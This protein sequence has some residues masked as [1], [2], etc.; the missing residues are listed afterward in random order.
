[1]NDSQWHE[2]IEHLSLLKRDQETERQFLVGRRDRG[3]DLASAVRIFLEVLHGYEAQCEQDGV[4]PLPV[5]ADMHPFVG[6]K[7]DSPAPIAGI[8]MFDGLMRE[9]PTPQPVQTKTIK[10]R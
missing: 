7:G 8:T 2:T 4:D 10:G 3:D 6:G 1:M 9:S 5:W